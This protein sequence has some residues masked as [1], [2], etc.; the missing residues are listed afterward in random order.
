MAL[1][2][3]MVL[4]LEALNSIFEIYQLKKYVYFMLLPC[5]VIS[6]HISFE[7]SEV[8]SFCHHETEENVDLQISPHELGY[9]KC[10]SC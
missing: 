4:D 1:L 3:T 10:E 8:C 5:I 9:E 7:Q 2:T 6:S